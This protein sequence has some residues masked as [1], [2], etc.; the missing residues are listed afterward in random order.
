M[1]LMGESWGVGMNA[2]AHIRFNEQWAAGLTYRSQ[3][4]HNVTG[5][6]K[7][8]RQDD[9]LGP[10]PELK[11]S[12]ASATVQL[13]DS[14]AL[15]VMWKPVPNLSFEA[16]TTWTRW[17]TYNAL[18]IYPDRAPS[19]ISQKS[20]RDGWTFNIGAEYSPLDW[21][22]LRLGFWHETAVTNEK[23]ADYLLPINGRDTLTAG[24]GFKWNSWTLDLAYAHIWIYPLSYYKSAGLPNSFDR[25]T[26]D[27][28]GGKVLPGTSKNTHADMFSVSL[29]YSF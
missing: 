10:L 3:M 28:R 25:V 8:K 29:G 21:L 5:K 11:D 18:N 15:A 20:W 14:A 26:G 24:V 2:A 19:S 1:N 27:P 13:P 17:S 6:V 9:S 12:D 23:Y 4:T 7:F 22:A 16:G